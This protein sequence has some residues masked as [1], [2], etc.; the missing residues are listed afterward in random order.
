[1]A[2]QALDPD[3]FRLVNGSLSIFFASSPDLQFL[4]GVRVKYGLASDLC[5]DFFKF[6]LGRKLGDFLVE[7]R[8]RESVKNARKE[9]KLALSVVLRHWAMTD[10]YA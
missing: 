4:D 10:R 3:Q 2:R 5:D 7:E 8:R 6:H 1:L 9:A